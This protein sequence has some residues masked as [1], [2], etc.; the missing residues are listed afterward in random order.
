MRVFLVLVLLLLAACSDNDDALRVVGELASERVL[1]TVETTEPIVDIAVA[2]GER[3]TKGQLL[4][5]QDTSRAEARLSEA[6]AAFAQAKAHLDELLRGPRREQV[7]QARAD[8]ERAQHEL[9]FRQAELERARKVFE[10]QLSSPEALD[11]AKNAHDTANA[12]LK[13]RQAR[14]E[15][16]LSGT[17]AEEL[18]QAE[19]SLRQASARQ[20]AAGIDLERHRVIAPVDGLIDTRLFEVGERPPAGQPVLVMLTGRQVHAEVYVPESLRVRIQPGTMASLDI[21]GLDEP[22][23]GRVRWVASESAFTPYYALTERDRG[24]LSYLAKID[25]VGYDERLPDGVP[26]EARFELD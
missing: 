15:E 13:Q 18:E 19:Q 10:R 26:V 3:V 24:R 1:I 5:E 14:L 8:A 9:E 6:E 17:T 16:L 23:N 7:D 11:Q 12:T 22:V 20:D 21:D 4:L 2:E 25:L